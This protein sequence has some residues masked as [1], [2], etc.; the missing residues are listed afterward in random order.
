MKDQSDNEAKKADFYE[1]LETFKIGMLGTMSS[2]NELRS[3]PMALAEIDRERGELWFVTSD[4]SGKADEILDDPRVNVTFQSTTRY[5]SISGGAQLH[6]DRERIERLWSDTWR[7]W[8]PDG[9]SADGLLLL[10]VRAHRGECW[11]V[12]GVGGVK[13]LIEWASSM[14][15]GSPIPSHAYDERHESVYLSA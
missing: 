6:D 12:S 1:A 2:G 4:D 10:R 14:L 5:I 11:D 15:T 9:P 7:P 8:F 13:L 3:R